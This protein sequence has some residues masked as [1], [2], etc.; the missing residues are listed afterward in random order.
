[1]QRT[2]RPEALTSGRINFT[3]L[4]RRTSFDSSYR[5]YVKIVYT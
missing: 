2:K 1:M 5:A 4:V 3:Y